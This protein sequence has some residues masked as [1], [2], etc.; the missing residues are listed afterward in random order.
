MRKQYPGEYVAYTES[1]DASRTVLAHD[2]TLKAVH[3]ALSHLS[4]AQIDAVTVTYCDA[5]GGAFRGG[6]DGRR[7]PDAPAPAAG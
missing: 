2:Q 1:A 5:P 7:L 4:E 6:Y 3:A